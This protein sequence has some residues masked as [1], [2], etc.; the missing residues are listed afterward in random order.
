MDSGPFASSL[1]LRL[2]CGFPFFI[3]ITDH[4]NVVGAGNAG[5]LHVGFT[6]RLTFA[7]PGEEPTVEEISVRGSPPCDPI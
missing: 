7:A 5:N 1:A 4:F 6:I 3:D 2:Y